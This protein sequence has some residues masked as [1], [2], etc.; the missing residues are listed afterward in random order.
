MDQLSLR[1]RTYV[2]WPGWA[3][4]SVNPDQLAA[5]GLYYSGEEDEVRCY[6]CHEKFSGWREGDIP[7]DVHRRSCP[8]CPVV[9]DL[10]SRTCPPLKLSASK[11]F[12]DEPAKLPGDVEVDC[13]CASAVKG[14]ETEEGQV[15]VSIARQTS[16]SS[17]SAASYTT[18]CLSTPGKLKPR[19]PTY[20]K[21]NR[22]TERRK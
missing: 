13:G 2:L 17:R 8:G 10:D 12:S 4:R 5:A 18:T 22:Q 11:S 16:R 6:S 1:R 3:P 14:R 15:D 20:C 7:L 21:P 19:R 9:K